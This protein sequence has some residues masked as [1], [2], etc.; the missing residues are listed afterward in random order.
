[1]DGRLNGVVVSQFLPH[2]IA[3]RAKHGFIETAWIHVIGVGHALG[4]GRS[5]ETLE[6]TEFAG[7]APPDHTALSVDGV[8][9]FELLDA[10]GALCG[11]EA[12][13][14]SGFAVVV[15]VA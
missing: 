6:S 4:L 2:A 8:Q 10:H 13:I 5:H 12:V 3:N 15:V 7:H 9:P 11:R 14:A 1:M